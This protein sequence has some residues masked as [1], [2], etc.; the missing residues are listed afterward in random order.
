M[1][2]TLWPSLGYQ[3]APAA[4]RFLV[5]AFGF[6]VEAIHGD[7]EGRIDQA[8]LRWD[9]GGKV[10]LHSAE[11]DT[12][13]FSSL[14]GRA[15]VGIYFHTADPDALYDRALA[16]GATAVQAPSDSP[17]GARNATVADPE[18]GLWSFGTYAG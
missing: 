2:P 10:T 9:E 4:L 3:D 6:E 1:R 16:A 8:V 13:T 18:G 17:L 5:D 11:P 12:V 15:P 14:A 7:P